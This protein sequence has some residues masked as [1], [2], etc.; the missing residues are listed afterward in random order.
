MK[1]IQEA[2]AFPIGVGADFDEVVAYFQSS[3][4]SEALFFMYLDFQ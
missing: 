2:L 1:Q 4:S 3:T